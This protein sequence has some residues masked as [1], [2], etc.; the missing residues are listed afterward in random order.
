MT[1]S[2]LAGMISN[3][4]VELLVQDCNILTTRDLILTVYSLVYIWGYHLPWC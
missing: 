2:N 4:M 3:G 1:K